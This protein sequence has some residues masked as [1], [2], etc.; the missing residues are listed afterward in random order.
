MGPLSLILLLADDPLIASAKARISVE[1]HCV[2]SA[3]ETDV[4]VCGLRNADRFRVPFVV[5][6]PGDPAHE[7]VRAERTRLLHQTSPLQ[8]LS[9]FQVGDGM[10]GVTATMGGDGGMSTRTPAPWT[11]AMIRCP[12]P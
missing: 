9:P 12:C 3:S 1:Q 6:D 5:H 10:A 7:G 4:T 11:R 2:P 8:E